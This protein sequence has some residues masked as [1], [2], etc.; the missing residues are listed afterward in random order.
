MTW[1]RLPLLFFAIVIDSQIVNVRDRS[2]LAAV[3]RIAVVNDLAFLFQFFDVRVQT[4][5]ADGADGCTADLEGHPFTRFRHEEL[6]R[7]QVRVETALR[8]AVGVRYMVA[9]DRLFP[10]QITNFRHDSVDL[11]GVVGILEERGPQKRNLIF[12]T[13]RQGLAMF[14]DSERTRT[15]N[16][17]IRSQMLYPVELWVQS[18]GD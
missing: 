10:R 12:K 17:L 5:F 18:E 7:L 4:H 1:S 9:R 2:V 11:C 15:S 13:N 8:L 16:L 6:L 3:F 14:G